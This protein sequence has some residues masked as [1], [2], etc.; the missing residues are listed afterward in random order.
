MATAC[1]AMPPPPTNSKRKQPRPVYDLSQLPRL[2]ES[3]METYTK[4]HTGMSGAEKAHARRDFRH[5]Y[6]QGIRFGLVGIRW[7]FN[8]CIACT[9]HETPRRLQR[10]LL[11]YPEIVLATEGR[12]LGTVVCLEH[13]AL[14]ETDAG[15]QD[16]ILPGALR[17]IR[18]QPLRAPTTS[19]AA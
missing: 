17:R 12:A 10:I 14:M 4:T 7:N 16:V 2:V 6:L 19:A 5:F 13:S 15:R 11:V 3:A 18:E 9:E 1:A 8:G